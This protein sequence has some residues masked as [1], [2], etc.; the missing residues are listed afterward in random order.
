MPLA[1][2]VFVHPLLYSLPAPCFQM[3]LP[4]VAG[5][6]VVAVL[7][8]PPTALGLDNGLALTPPMG[9]LAWE[10]FRCN[11]DCVNDPKNCIRSVTLFREAIP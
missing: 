11:T 1:T 3:G 8:L 7:V 10:R 5:I 9:W 6:L 4:R 2:H